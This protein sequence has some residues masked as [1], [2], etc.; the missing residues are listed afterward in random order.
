MHPHQHTVTVAQFGIGPIGAEIA[1]LILTKPWLQ[2]VA[3][4]DA[5]PAKVGRDL[6][7]VIGLGRTVGVVVT[8]RLEVAAEVICHST[9]SRLADE[10]AVLTSLLARGSHVI[11]TCEE[12]AYPVDQDI[13]ESLQK[14]ARSHAVTLLGTGVNPG[15]VMDKLPLTL[16]AAC[17]QVRGIEIERVLDA[18]RRRAP[19]QR[20]VGAG[21]SPAA[22]REEVAAGRMRL[23]GLRESLLMLANGMHLELASVSSERIEP[24]I[25][26]EDVDTGVLRVARGSVAGIHQTIGATAVNGTTFSLDIR[27]FVGAEP[28]S[29]TILIHGIPDI[30]AVIEGGVHG[31]TA[32]AAMVVNAIPRVLHTHHGLLSMDDIPVGFR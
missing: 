17:E 19:L 20:K 29:D 13:R 18:S 8:E 21:L 25:A 3:A 5:D 32:T 1:R 15:F 10:L 12:L 16:T 23:V 4:V 6:G 7:E 2:L 28:S 11:S 30:K 14:T 24:V 31:D 22:F 27:I 9:G 26:K